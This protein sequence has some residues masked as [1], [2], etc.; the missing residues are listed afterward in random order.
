MAIWW[1]IAAWIS[2]AERGGGTGAAGIGPNERRKSPTLLKLLAGVLPIPI[3]EREV[4]HNV[5]VGYFFS[6]I[7]RC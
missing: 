1:S 7:G 5:K 4:G 6:S 3:G 2:E